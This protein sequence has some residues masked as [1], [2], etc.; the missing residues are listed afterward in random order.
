MSCTIPEQQLE[1]L[2]ACPL[3]QGVP[4]QQLLP[5]AQRPGCTLEHFPAGALIYSPSHFHRRLGVLLSG[6]VRVTKLSLTVS[7]LTPGALFGAVILV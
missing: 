7:V 5:L 3:F 6:Q 4:A 2:A 1:L